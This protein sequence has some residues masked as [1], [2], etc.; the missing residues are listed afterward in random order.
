M[1]DSSCPIYS[2][3]IRKACGGV[4]YIDMVETREG[5][6]IA[7]CSLLYEHFF[8]RSELEFTQRLI[9]DTLDYY[10]KHGLDDEDIK[11][12]N[13]ALSDEQYRYWDSKRERESAR[14]KKR[15]NPAKGR[16]T[17]IYV[18][19]DASSSSLKVGKSTNPKSRL[20]GLQTSNPNTL[21][22]TYEHNGYS[23]DEKNIHQR[24][25]DAGL[26]IKG[27]WFKDSQETIDIIKEYF[28]KGE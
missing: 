7:F 2:S 24:L 25:T 10:D 8:N 16:K 5:T 3:F 6:N 9:K 11:M 23:I 15:S 17:V 12:I 14:S 22:L 4:A 18:I 19:R 1:Q 21:E 28:S 26:H 27:E 13:K 20:K